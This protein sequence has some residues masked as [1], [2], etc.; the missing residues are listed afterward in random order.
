M[1]EGV[2]AYTSG[3]KSIAFLTPGCDQGIGKADIIASANAWIGICGCQ[4]H[5][6]TAEGAGDGDGLAAARFR[7]AVLSK[8]R[9]SQGM[10]G[11]LKICPVKLLGPRAGAVTKEA[12]FA[13][14]RS[15]IA[16]LNAQA[17]KKEIDA[18]VAVPLADVTDA[19][20]SS[21]SCQ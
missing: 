14:E 9:A 5:E 3:S 4:C 6:E 17:E 8:R 15:R 12:R 21:E 13:R 7:G 19:H 18:V 2:D 20:S 10:L 1:Q 16:S 11:P